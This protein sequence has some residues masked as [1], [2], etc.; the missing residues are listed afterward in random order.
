M[1][2]SKNIDVYLHCSSHPII[3]D[4]VNIRFTKYELPVSNIEEIFKVR[5]I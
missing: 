2:D 5:T 1:H 4:C 3:E